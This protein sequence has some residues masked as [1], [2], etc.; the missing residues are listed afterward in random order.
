M[1][2]TEKNIDKLVD[3]LKKEKDQGNRIITFMDLIEIGEP[4]VQPLIELLMGTI[5]H[6]SASAA[7]ALGEMGEEGK[8]AIPSLRLQLK[9][10]S[11]KI[12]FCSAFALAKLDCYEIIDELKKMIRIEKDPKLQFY[13]MLALYRLEGKESTM[14]NKIINLRKKNKITDQD[15]L[16]FQ[17]IYNQIN[18][19]SAMKK[20]TDKTETI[21][22]D[23]VRKWINRL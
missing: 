9:N 8:I 2:F 1:K 17:E 19:K 3:Y 10:S 16:L 4:A 20:N 14:K 12:R 22:V 6:L 7:R 21:S 23:E 11:D 13:Y 15:M 18:L 5:E